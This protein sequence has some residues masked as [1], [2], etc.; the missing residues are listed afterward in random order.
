MVGYCCHE[1]HARCSQQ[2]SNP[3]A[4]QLAPDKPSQHCCSKGFLG[5][6]CQWCSCQVGQAGEL[7]QNYLKTQFLCKRY[8]LAPWAVTGSTATEVGGIPNEVPTTTNCYASILPWLIL[9]VTQHFVYLSVDFVVLV[10]PRHSC[11]I[12]IKLACVRAGWAAGHAEAA[13]TAK[14]CGHTTTAV[15]SLH[16]CSLS[17]LALP[18]FPMHCLH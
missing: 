13:I 5:H 16:L 3:A 4:P 8:W 12:N 2:V 14:L 18:I 17:F 15:C 7:A 6:W 1:A 10:L 9:P 11:S